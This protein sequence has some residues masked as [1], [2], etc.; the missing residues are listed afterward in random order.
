MSFRKPVIAFNTPDLEPLSTDYEEGWESCL[1][2]PTLQCA[3]PRG[4]YARAAF[5]AGRVIPPKCQPTVIV[6]HA[7]TIRG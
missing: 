4:R 2:V 5:G 3:A 1:C 7:G 6:V